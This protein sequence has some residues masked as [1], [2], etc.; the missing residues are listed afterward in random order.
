MT[1]PVIEENWAPVACSSSMSCLVQSQISTWN[2]R[3][4]MCRTRSMIGSSV[5][6]ISAHAASVKSVIIVPM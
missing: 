2:P 6:I 1:Y 4:S 3:S 5:K